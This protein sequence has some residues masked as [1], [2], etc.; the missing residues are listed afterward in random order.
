MDDKVPRRYTA[1]VILSPAQHV[2]PDS[3]MSRMG[4][5]WDWY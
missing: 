2:I 1:S 3:Y 4:A 5:R